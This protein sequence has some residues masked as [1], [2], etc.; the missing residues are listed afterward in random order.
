MIR[1]EDL[2]RGWH[3]LVLEP[4]SR[5][6]VKRFLEDRLTDA[7]R[8]GD[9]DR[10]ASA[11]DYLF[12][13]L[14]LGF[15]EGTEAERAAWAADMMPR[16]LEALRF[17]DQPAVWRDHLPTGTLF[18]RNALL[19]QG[20]SRVK[21]AEWTAEFAFWIFMVLYHLS[22]HDQDDEDVQKTAFL[23][24]RVL[25]R[26]GLPPAALERHA[27]SLKDFVLASA[28]EEA[29]ASVVS[30]VQK[31]E[32]SSDWSLYRGIQT[33]R[34]ELADLRDVSPAE[35]L[36]RWWWGGEAPELGVRSHILHWALQTME[37]F[38][39][40]SSRWKAL[41]EELRLKILG[42]SV[43]APDLPSR[44]QLYHWLSTRGQRSRDEEDII[45]S[46]SKETLRAESP[47]MEKR[48]LLTQ[49]EGWLRLTAMKFT[50][51][52]KIPKIE[53]IL[54]PMKKGSESMPLLPQLKK[55]DQ[56]SPT[57]DLLSMLSMLTDHI[58]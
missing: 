31:N 34:Q 28:H 52:R 37:A 13:Q 3:R 9:G 50:V 20:R 41:P 38:H 57:N 45:Q 56:A 14:R 48:H 11:L 16:V 12:S 55:E 2:R 47:S 19:D 24:M 21:R 39:Q 27:L 32:E 17:L 7:L 33:L 51:I 44:T 5:K 23:A 22:F 42:L 58:F 29:L 10:I 18:L 1:E 6:E 43:P 8:A 15:P 49:S 53:E 54:I 4:E 40:A 26:M 25:F 36:L 35:A 30:K 46:Y